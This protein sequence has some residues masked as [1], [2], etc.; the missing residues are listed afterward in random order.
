MCTAVA[1]NPVTWTTSGSYLLADTDP[2]ATGAWS[3]VLSTTYPPD[4]S[5]VTVAN[6]SAS[7]AAHLVVYGMPVKVGCCTGL[8]PGAAGFRLRTLVPN[9]PEVC[10]VFS[11]GG[12]GG[13]CG[14]RWLVVVGDPVLAPPSPLPPAPQG[15]V[16]ELAE[17]TAL[18]FAWLRPPPSPNLAGYR[19]RLR[20]QRG[21]PK[22]TVAG[23][24]LPPAAV[25]L[26]VDGLVPGNAY[27]LELWQELVRPAGAGPPA[28]YPDA[29]TLP[30]PLFG[31][32]YEL[33]QVVTLPADATTC[34]MLIAYADYDAEAVVPGSLAPPVPLNGAFVSA[35]AVGWNQWWLRGLTY[36]P[37][38]APPAHALL[39]LQ[40]TSSA[41]GSTLLRGTLDVVVPLVPA[42]SAQGDLAVFWDGEGSGDTYLRF[43]WS[44]DPTYTS[45]YVWRLEQGVASGGQTVQCGSL[46]DWTTGALVVRGLVPLT[47][48]AL[49]LRSAPVF[50]VPD[51][52]TVASLVVPV[53]ATTS[54]PSCSACLTPFVYSASTLR[55]QVAAGSYCA[56]LAYT[57]QC[58]LA[59]AVQLGWAPGVTP[60]AG[61]S[62]SSPS[63]GNWTVTGLAAGT[64]YAMVLTAPCAAGGQVC[65]GGGPG[66][67]STPVKFTTPAGALCSAGTL[68]ASCVGSATS[69]FSLTFTWTG[70]VAFSGG[71]AWTLTPQ[72]G[73]PITGSSTFAPLA[74]YMF[75]GLTPA[76]TYTFVIQGL[77]AGGTTVTSNQ[78]VATTPASPAASLQA[79][80]KHQYVFGA[81]TAVYVLLTYTGLMLGGV[82]PTSLSLQVTAPGP[83]PTPVPAVSPASPN[84]WLVPGLTI[85]D[86]GSVQ[87]ELNATGPGG[88]PV[89]PPL[90]TTLYNPT[91]RPSFVRLPFRLAVTHY[92]G[93]PETIVSDGKNIAGATPYEDQF[94]DA[95]E[96]GTPG[97]WSNQAAFNQTFADLVVGGF[98]AAN[99]QRAL[100]PVTGLPE[101]TSPVY[102]SLDQDW[103]GL[104][105]D[106]VYFGVAGDPTLQGSSVP[107]VPPGGTAYTANRGYALAES[108]CADSATSLVVSPFVDPPLLAWYKALVA[109]NDACLF[110][111]SQVWNPTP[112]QLA[113]NAYGSKKTLEEWWYASAFEYPGGAPGPPT[114][115]GTLFAVPPYNPKAVPSVVT[116]V[117]YD[118]TPG[119]TSVAAAQAGFNCLERWFQYVA[120][121][122]Q[123]LREWMLGGSPPDNALGLPLSFGSITP[124][125]AVYYQISAVTAD[126]EGNGFPNIAEAPVATA[127]PPAEVNLTLKTLWNYWVNQAATPAATRPSWWA[128]SFPY[129]PP[130]PRVNMPPGTDF[131]LPCNISMTTPGLIYGMTDG[132]VGSPDYDA[133]GAV[134]HEVYDTESAPFPYLGAG[135][136]FVSVVDTAPGDPDYGKPVSGLFFTPAYF[137]GLDAQAAAGGF[138]SVTGYWDNLV[139]SGP[140]APSGG[141]TWTSTGGASGQL[142][143][144]GSGASGQLTVVNYS[145]PPSTPLLQRSAGTNP[146]AN[147]ALVNTAPGWLVPPTPTGAPGQEDVYALGWA[148]ESSRYDLWNGQWA[149]SLVA[150]TTAALCYGQVTQGLC[151]DPPCNG[152]SIWSDLSMGFKPV[153]AG[154][155]S[156]GVATPAAAAGN[157]YMLSVQAGPWVNC[158]SL[159][160]SQ[161]PLPGQPPVPY[162]GP[163]EYRLGFSCPDGALDPT[164]PFPGWV[165]MAGQYWGPYASQLTGQLQRW[166]MNQALLDGGGATDP[167]QNPVESP[168]TEDNFGVFA[169]FDVVIA[170]YQQAAADLSSGALGASALWR[171]GGSGSAPLLPQL[172]LYELGFVPLA[173]CMPSYSL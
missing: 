147:A 155:N 41:D 120:Y 66:S 171:L 3:L 21:A 69:P 157:V 35:Q 72:T 90:T 156:A 25:S 20:L 45:G 14:G 168:A 165:G 22:V 118:G 52:S 6:V 115:P 33:L 77:C 75:T 129:A 136:N 126:G 46:P 137:A 125:Q 167:N 117:P 163:S 81:G 146:W 101:C 56:L 28:V 9:D 105:Y 141:L 2:A 18:A 59:G 135:S 142:A 40:A 15:L 42:T 50:G 133:V 67:I 61:S 160:A 49:Y 150:G 11:R 166:C 29:A 121:L 60:P 88:V 68:T 34:D 132:D 65:C 138:Q 139:P 162:A 170:A 31:P 106:A 113:M 74:E 161:R 169:D 79:G 44:P 152:A 131:S 86:T 127:W 63:A 54:T 87:V 80:W 89:D 71:F 154:I 58:A 19:W 94:I 164:S 39:G 102:P 173:W 103:Y 100:W 145:G 57:D 62:I 26:R 7:P 97:T 148:L 37:R 38:A 92:G 4:G 64:A 111:G 124:D 159:A 13:G 84:K 158:L 93:P 10:F 73:S 95:G 32:D 151:A 27:T 99:S 123:R 24:R 23:G 172:G 122:N 109:Y 128:A 144:G 78:V 70:T 47:S 116:G 119:A 53:P 153:V 96:V 98:V 110:H 82:D 104:C 36:S 143:Q 55:F 140:L 51:A 134:F 17:P 112:V 8:P 16:L 130:Q 30:S 149:A 1:P 107:A 43:Y 12:G 91:Q 114:P 76:T 85:S 108:Y 83:T 5:R 48:Y